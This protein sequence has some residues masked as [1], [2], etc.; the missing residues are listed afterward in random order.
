MD[1]PGSFPLGQ[2]QGPFPFCSVSHPPV[3][4]WFGQFLLAEP[5]KASLLLW[6]RASTRDLRDERNHDDPS[7]I[8]NA[9]LLFL[10]LSSQRGGDL[11]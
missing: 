2:E 10:P 8:Q 6:P 3:F 1:G 5:G 9:D 4:A 7:R 11:Q